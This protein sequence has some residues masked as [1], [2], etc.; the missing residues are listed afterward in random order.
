MHQEAKDTSKDNILDKTTESSPSTDSKVNVATVSMFDI[1]YPG[2]ELA[3][4]KYWANKRNYFILVLLLY[5]VSEDTNWI[6]RCL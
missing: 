2:E 5:S 6:L 1:I 4:K 3:V